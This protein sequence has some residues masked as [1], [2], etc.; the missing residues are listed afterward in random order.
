MA[1]I[2]EDDREPG[3]YVL[4]ID[5]SLFSAE[6]RQLLA[7]EQRDGVSLD[8]LIL[9]ALTAAF[10][11]G[12]METAY[13]KLQVLE[14]GLNGFLGC[15]LEAFLERLETPAVPNPPNPQT[16]E[17]A[18]PLAFLTGGRSKVG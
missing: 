6:K 12:A 1:W 4:Y 16:A 5:V 10:T 18:K 11:N 9:R 8:D 14:H 3:E 7:L 13:W 2:Q 17:P 15:A